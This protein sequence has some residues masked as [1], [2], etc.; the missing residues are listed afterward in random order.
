VA[1]ADRPRVRNRL[2][3]KGT[4]ASSTT[5]PKIVLYSLLAQEVKGKMSMGVECN[6]LNT[7][8][9]TSNPSYSRRTSSR[10]SEDMCCDY[11]LLENEF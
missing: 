3:E 1:S 6:I 7:S 11:L 9:C 5:P 8:P 4:R 10:I 2:S